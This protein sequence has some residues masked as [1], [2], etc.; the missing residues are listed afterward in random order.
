[1]PIATTL[2]LIA[3]DYKNANHWYWRLTGAD[4]HFLADQ[5]VRLDTTDSEYEGFLDLPAYL[6]VH[7]A[8]R[9]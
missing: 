5:E 8:Q 4:G 6:A 9:Q 1:M 2:N 7:A 3:I